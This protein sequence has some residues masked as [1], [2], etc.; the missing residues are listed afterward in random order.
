MSRTVLVHQPQ[1]VRIIVDTS[2]TT[3]YGDPFLFAAKCWPALRMRFIV[4]RQAS[5][6]CTKPGADDSRDEQ[7]DETTPQR[8]A[9]LR[10]LHIRRPTRA[11][12]IAVSHPALERKSKSSR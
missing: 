9:G 7:S 4:A 10:R 6:R 2:A 3:A 12:R 8:S 5:H 11:R 1:Q